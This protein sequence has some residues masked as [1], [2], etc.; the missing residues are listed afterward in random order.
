MQ[1]MSEIYATQFERVRRAVRKVLREPAD[2]DNV[3]QQLFAD[4]VAERKLR[5]SYDKG[6]IGAWLCA[7]ACHKAIDFGRRQARLIAFD[8]TAAVQATLPRVGPLDDFK[9]DLQRF[10][11]AQP[12]EKQVLLRLRFVE[13]LTQNEVA[14]QMNTPRSTVET[15][16][17]QLKQELRVFLLGPTGK[18]AH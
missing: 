4:L 8:E 1:V 18:A 5:E 7:I 16:E 15:W 3:V 10:A 11:Q 17:H 6:D 13:G 14:T 12:H 9:Q 2:Q